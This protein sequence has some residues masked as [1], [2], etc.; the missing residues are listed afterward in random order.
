[1]ADKSVEGSCFSCGGRAGRIL[2]L[3]FDIIDEDISGR[4]RDNQGQNEGST[5]GV[6]CGDKSFAER[7]GDPV[8]VDDP[9]DRADITV[10][11]FAPAE[12]DLDRSVL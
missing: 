2:R 11:A 6:R 9:F 1:M 7:H 8:L 12:G 5:N 4:L 10:C 3:R